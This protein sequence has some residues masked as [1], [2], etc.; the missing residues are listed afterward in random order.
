MFY[1]LRVLLFRKPPVMAIRNWDELSDHLVRNSLSDWS[2]SM[3]SGDG[4][5]GGMY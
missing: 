2:H 3:E 5:G 1:H 4:D